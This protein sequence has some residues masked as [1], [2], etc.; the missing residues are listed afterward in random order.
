[1]AFQRHV[2][3]ALAITS[4][5]VAGCRSGDRLLVSNT[6][7]VPIVFDR[8]NVVGACANMAFTF[9]GAWHPQGQEGNPPL[10]SSPVPGAIPVLIEYRPPIDGLGST[11]TVAIVSEQGVTIHKEADDPAAP[12]GCVGQPPTAAIPSNAPTVAPGSG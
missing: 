4:S 1:L 12:T 10:P 8:S 5:V 2:F 7:A 3:V 11:R 6:T 9:Q